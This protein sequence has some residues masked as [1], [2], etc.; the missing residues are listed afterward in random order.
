MAGEKIVLSTDK[1]VSSLKPLSNPEDK[2]FQEQLAAIRAL[3]KA[4]QTIDELPAFL[5]VRLSVAALIS[6]HN[7]SPAAVA[8]AMKL[9]SVTIEQLNVA[10][11][12]RYDGNVLVAVVAATEDPIVRSKRDVSGRTTDPID[13]VRVVCA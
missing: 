7:E 3:S 4:L 6:A 8:E 13:D 2:L 10:A 12:K 11:Q 5:S 9:L 1:S